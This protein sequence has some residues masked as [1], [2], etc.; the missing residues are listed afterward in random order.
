[1]LAKL[2]RVSN[3]CFFFISKNL[4]DEKKKKRKLHIE[5]TLE[6]CRVIQGLSMVYIE[7]KLYGIIF[8]STYPLQLGQLPFQYN[9]GSIING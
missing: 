2:D 3:E 7:G 9:N 5:T 1:M 8:S 4:S 6:R